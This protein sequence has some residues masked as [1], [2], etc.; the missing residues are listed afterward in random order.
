N[1]TGSTPSTISSPQAKPSMVAGGAECSR[2]PSCAGGTAPDGPN[3]NAASDESAP[4]SSNADLPPPALFTLRTLYIH[5][6]GAVLRCEDEHLRVS[7]DNL[8]L[9]S[10]PAFK[11]DQIVLFGNSQVTTS[12]MKFCL[13]RNIPIV[14]LSGRGDF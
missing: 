3:S 10:L 7:K 8:E 4:E 11:V 13:R 6:H 9:L 2:L 5:E 14:V 1:R 12:A